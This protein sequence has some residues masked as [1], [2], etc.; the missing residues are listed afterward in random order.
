VSLVL[1]GSATLAWLYPDEA[2]NAIL[3]VFDEVIRSGAAVP[4]LWRIEVANSL[5]MSVRRG[6]ITAEERESSLADL[7]QLRIGID[8]E[9]EYVWTDA[10]RL[11]DFHSLTVYDATYLELAVRLSLP[12]ATLDEDLR[13]AAQRERVPLLGK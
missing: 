4:Y 3:A 12:L 7:G 13:T 6:R 9:T 8:R 10:L 5:T 11:A 1:D 2:T